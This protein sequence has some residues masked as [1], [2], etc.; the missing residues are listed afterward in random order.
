MKRIL[1]LVSL[2]PPVLCFAQTVLFLPNHIIIQPNN[3]AES[4]PKDVQ[5]YFTISANLD[6]SGCAKQQDYILSLLIYRN[7][8]DNKIVSTYRAQDGNSL[9]WID[10]ISYSDKLSPDMSAGGWKPANPG[11]NTW[12]SQ[13]GIRN[14][15]LCPIVDI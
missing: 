8:V 3:P 14:P 5:N 9:C 7:F 10:L 11:A 2:F 12:C 1:V 4:F 15:N 13:D 6:G